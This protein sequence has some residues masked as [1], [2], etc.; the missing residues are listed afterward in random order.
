[1]QIYNTQLNTPIEIYTDQEP[2]T[3]AIPIPTKHP[4]LQI[5]L[6]KSVQESEY[7]K[8]NFS[9]ILAHG[10]NSTE[11]DKLVIAITGARK[12]ASVI[13]L[14]CQQRSY[15]RQQN[16]QEFIQLKRLAQTLTSQIITRPPPAKSKNIA[17]YEV[18]H[19]SN[20][21][22]RGTASAAHQTSKLAKKGHRA[23]EV[24]KQ[25]EAD[26]NI[27]DIEAFNGICYR[28]LLNEQTPK[29]RAIHDSSGKRLGLISRSIDNFRSLHDYYKAKKA[30]YGRF[31]SPPQAD[32]IEARIG[33]ILAAAY[34]GEEN[35]LHGGNIGYDPINLLSYKI[36]HDQATW[37]FTSKYRNANPQKIVEKTTRRAHGIRPVDAFPITQRDI[38]NFPHLTDA[39]PNNFP[40]RSD[41]AVLNLTRI[42][43]NEDFIYDAFSIFLKAALTTKQVYSNIANATIR[44]EKLR[45]RLVNHK[46]ER[47]ELL[48][49][50]LIQNEKFA[51]FVFTHPNLKRQLLAELR[52]Y[53]ED[54]K[55]TSPLHVDLA[56]I[57]QEFDRV[58]ERCET[59]YF[60][61]NDAR[62]SAIFEAFYQPDNDYAQDLVFDSKERKNNTLRQLMTELQI[63]KASAERLFVRAS[64]LWLNKPENQSKLVQ[65][66]QA[67]ERLDTILQDL[68][69][70]D[71]KVG[72]F[73]GETCQLEDGKEIEIA[74]GAAAIF[75][76]YQ[77]YK[78]GAQPSAVEA[79]NKIIIQAHHSNNY[80]GHYFFNRRQEETSLFYQK[81][82]SIE[83]DIL[84][85]IAEEP[86][87]N[88]FGC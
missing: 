70:L 33:R 8:H 62:L 28:L 85:N 25:A 7:F 47:S 57:A 76:N 9:K 45:E 40:D 50:E 3:L 15:I 14:M 1:M 26:R 17:A 38:S 23:E 59:L 58:K 60:A 84:Q 65:I 73:G 86:T 30:R 29:V 22:Q 2:T 21:M 49:T 79:L 48:K 82:M 78:S 12:I 63:N 11:G 31:R 37:P 75:E 10:Y 74:K 80:Q 55:A 34:F 39:K 6:P 35:D 32:L 67:E 36:D 72:F 5:V 41:S 69:A 87:S 66:Q 4:Y 19:D 88:C 81:V 20:E 44:S 43:E 56:P 68:I 18:V 27:I 77:E 13:H 51:K 53:N 46:T 54:Y 52:E 16:T 64:K 71:G 83:P 61:Q 24:F 42:E